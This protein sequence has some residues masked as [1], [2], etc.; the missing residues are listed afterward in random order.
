MSELVE[1]CSRES[2]LSSVQ[3][4]LLRQLSARLP[5]V[6]DLARAHLGLYVPAGR[7][8]FLPVEQVCSGTV[9]AWA[10]SR[11]A[12]IGQ[13]EERLVRETFRVGKPLAEWREAEGGAAGA[14][15]YVIKDFGGKNIAVVALSFRLVLPMEEY[16]HLLHGAGLVLMHG[17]RLDPAVYARLTMEDGVL[18]ADRFHRIVFADEI[19]LHI[20]RALG[21]GSLV[22]RSL[23]DLCLKRGIERETIA[24]KF[25]WEREMQARGRILKERRM[26]FA[27]GGNALGELVILSDITELRQREQEARIQEALVQR[28]Q[29][30]E[31]ELEHLK[32]SLEMRKLLDRAKGILMDAHHITEVESYRR[33]QRYAMTKRMS[34]RE[35]AEAILQAAKK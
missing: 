15:T 23:P 24:R 12:A 13:A 34:I 29:E 3:I 19:V 16:T 22:G 2:S 6:A 8:K 11:D 25:P 14:K 31:D 17:G 4:E 32:D 28:I 1:F 35:V 27:E 20:Y 9:A 30:L 26:E 33:I 7:E 21:V 5:F 18:L 10:D